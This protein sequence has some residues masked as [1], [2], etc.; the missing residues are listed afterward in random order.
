[1]KRNLYN[2]VALVTLLFASCST[3][4]PESSTVQSRDIPQTIAIDFEANDTRL[5][6][7]DGKTTLNVGDKFYVFNKIN[8]C[9]T[10]VYNGNTN[11]E[12]KPI[13]ELKDTTG[14]T[15]HTA[16][17]KFVI[18]YNETQPEVYVNN[19]SPTTST[20]SVKSNQK[21]IK[22]SY[23]VNVAPMVSV[24]EDLGSTLFKNVCGWVKLSI[25]GNGETVEKIELTGNNS[26]GLAFGS[27]PPTKINVNDLSVYSVGYAAKKLTMTFNNKDDQEESYWDTATLSS[28]PTDFYF[29]MPPVEFTR[30]FTVKI[31]CTDGTVMTKS[32]SKK[33]EVGRNEVQP[34]EVF[35]YVGEPI[36]L[37]ISDL[38]NPVFKDLTYIEGF[39]DTFEIKVANSEVGYFIF[40][41]SGY[42]AAGDLNGEYE[43]AA[44]PI[45]TKYSKNT[46]VADPDRCYIP[47]DG[48]LYYFKS[49]KVTVSGTAASTTIA[50]DA[51]VTNSSGAELPLVGSCTLADMGYT[52]S[53]ST[54]L[55]AQGLTAFKYK[56]SGSTTTIQ[57]GS[58]SSKLLTLKVNCSNIEDIYDKTYSTS[59]TT[60]PINDGSS[61][62]IGGDLGQEYPNVNGEF[63]I[64]KVNNLKVKIT[65][66]NMKFVDQAGNI[67]EFNETKEVSW[68]STTTIQEPGGWF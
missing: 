26:E 41:N 24:S 7:E 33:I 68:A 35:E 66:T 39:A 1:M 4:L 9:D 15:Q 18:I 53:T 6:L 8:H 38:S 21:Y 30:G 23:A 52:T 17:D 3:E 58:T 20:I 55:Q 43:I 27:N 64:T 56:V 5:H 32:T 44:G 40:Y 62:Y 60:Y 57:A 48:E 16:M 29:A 37:D 65:F 51:V 50:F 22:D 45:G 59:S 46:L 63:S 49:G 28:T 25:I 14:Y 19:G 54:T 31:S 2:L 61:F 13:I 67:Y 34:M 36:K 12:G 10:Y 47:Y 11:D 42:R